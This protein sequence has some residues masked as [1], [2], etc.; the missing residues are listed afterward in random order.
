MENIYS[1]ERKLAAAKKQQEIIDGA[2][3]PTGVVIDL[4]SPEGNVFYILGHGFECAGRDVYHFT[5][6]VAITHI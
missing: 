2:R 6:V 3:V 4:A 5:I 1:I